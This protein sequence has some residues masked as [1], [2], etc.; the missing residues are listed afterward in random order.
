MTIK[1]KIL[2]GLGN[3][4]IDQGKRVPLN[5]LRLATWVDSCNDGKIYLAM[6]EMEHNVWG[7]EYLISALERAVERGVSLDIIAE[8]EELVPENLRP[9]AR[10][11]DVK[12]G[13]AIIDTQHR[14]R[15]TS[16]LMKFVDNGNSFPGYDEPA[17]IAVPYA[18][19]VTP[20]Y[21]GKYF[22]VET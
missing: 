17:A 10:I 21:V 16:N 18:H 4:L 2:N 6:R 1:D 8:S 15:I 20:R 9:Y 3:I 14:K 11:T 7:R 12:E 5:S 13:L 22:S 19:G